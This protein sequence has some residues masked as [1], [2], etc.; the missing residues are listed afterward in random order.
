M[1]E[2]IVKKLHESDTI[3]LFMHINPDGDCIGSC[4]AFYK[5]LLNIG[6]TPY[7]FLEPNN[8]IKDNLQFLPN[9]NVINEKLGTIRHLDLAIALDCGDAN[10][11]G[12]TAYK[13]F[14]KAEDT[15]C[16]DH[17]EM[18]KPFVDALVLEPKA[19][20]TTQI[21][22]KVLVEMD[23]SAMDKDI[24]TCL[25]TGLSSDSGSL[26]YS[27]TS[28]ESFAVAAELTKLGASI[29]EINRRLYKDTQMSTFKLTNRVLGNAQFFYDD[30]LAIITFRKEDFESTGTNHTNTDGI[31]N[32]L[33]DVVDVKL[34]ITIAESEENTYKIGIRAK[35]GVNAGKFAAIFGGGGH[36]AASG[37]RLYGQYSD[38][39]EKLIEN[40]PSA[41]K[42]II[43]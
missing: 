16:I 43:K 20:S 21:L 25:M 30:A 7:I 9:I 34:A 27:S 33:I 5:F 22:Y 6:K 4:L 35:D 36:F 38:V 42:D 41:L 2:H 31:I 29:Y 14:L 8:K 19:A 1:Y 15:A 13:I 18:S 11:L 12:A 28:A 10:R 32:R 17:H 23:K 24:A 39:L 40:A 37:C 3:G 26:T